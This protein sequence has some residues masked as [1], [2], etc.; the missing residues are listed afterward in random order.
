M[1]PNEKQVGGAHYA[2]AVQHWD[3]VAAVLHDRYLEGC[4]TKYITRYKK[5]NGLQDLEKAL[6]YAEKLLARFNAGTVQ[7][8]FNGFR[9][10]DAVRQFAKANELDINQSALINKLAHWAGP[11]DLEFVIKH[12]GA[13]M[14]EFKS[15]AAPAPDFAA[16]REEMNICIPNEMAPFVLGMVARYYEAKKHYAGAW[17]QVPV[18]RLRLGLRRNLISGSHIDVC[19]YAMFLRYRDVDMVFA[20]GESD[21]RISFSNRLLMDVLDGVPIITKSVPAIV[22]ELAGDEPTGAYIKQG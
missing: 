16:V 17:A 14:K 21:P 13:L 10:D 2:A 7:P 6:H 22:T 5:K 9:F 11:S 8:L 15:R 18:D 12:L 3:F 1:N 4:C 20:R 19:L